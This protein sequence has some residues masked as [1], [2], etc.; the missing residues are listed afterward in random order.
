MT[1]S[2]YQPATARPP[3]PVRGPLAAQLRDRRLGP[4]CKTVLLVVAFGTFVGL[5]VAAVGGLVVL[6][7]AARGG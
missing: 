4:F 1:T 2:V 7:L 6:E 5:L 3:A